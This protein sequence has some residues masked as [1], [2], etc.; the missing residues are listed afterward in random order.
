VPWR[1]LLAGSVQEA[2]E[3]IDIGT[4]LIYL[5]ITTCSG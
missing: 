1:Q 4:K 2:N 3:D 5:G